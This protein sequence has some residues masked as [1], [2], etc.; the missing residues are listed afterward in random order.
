MVAVAGVGVYG[1]LA[2][3]HQDNKTSSTVINNAD[4]N[5]NP[6]NNNTSN[7]IKNSG[8]QYRIE[9]SAAAGRPY[10]PICGSNNVDMTGEQYTDAKN[11]IQYQVHC[12]YCGNTWYT[13]GPY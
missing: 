10:C 6:A 9:G 5:N 8:V 4:Q 2:S 12:N 13:R 1:I 11:I 3:S 7:S